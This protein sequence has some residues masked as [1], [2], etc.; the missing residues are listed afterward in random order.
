MLILCVIS[1]AHSNEVKTTE[2]KASEMR[3]FTCYNSLT[4]SDVKQAAEWGVN[5][6]RVMLMITDLYDLNTVGFDQTIMPEKMELLK[7]SVKLNKKYGITTII[8]LHEMPGLVRWSHG[9][10][11][12]RLW[13]ED[14]VGEKFRQ[15]QVDTW[16]QIVE[17]FKNEPEGVVVYELFNE[18]EPKHND[19]DAPE[20]KHDMWNVQQVKILK[21]IREIDQ[22]HW[23]IVTPPYGWRLNSFSNWTPD[24]AIV[25]DGKVIAT[26]HMYH[27]HDFTIQW[28]NWEIYD[29]EGKTDQLAQYPGEFTGHLWRKTFWDK[30]RVKE[31]MMPLKDFQESYPHIPLIVTEFTALRVAP[32]ADEYL[33][34]V[35][36]IM[37]EWGIGW[38]YHTYKEMAFLKDKK[39]VN[40]SM[41]DLEVGP[42]DRLKVIKEGLKN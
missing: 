12:F 41:W 8:D 20:T 33:S 18:P 35:I 5:T 3:G 42:P 13:N 6:L 22:R 9:Y 32:G 37:Q 39:A 15:L 10:K 11:D 7:S 27:P 23:V 4:E 34:D 16:V 17:E 14:W 36:A 2:V 1:V 21:K 19:W 25:N 28:A 40:D 24:D 30:D 31:S 26:A 29:K 38:T